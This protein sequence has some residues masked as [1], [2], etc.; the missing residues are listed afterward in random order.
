MLCL[1]NGLA[2]WLAFILVRK[3]FGIEISLP[4]IE[5]LFHSSQLGL[6]CVIAM[7]LDMFYC[8]YCCCYCYLL[9]YKCGAAAECPQFST[10]KAL[11]C[12]YT[13]LH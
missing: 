7:M 10:S 13:A 4:I 5:K 1:A 6:A 2:G 9:L 3:R 12:N 11:A 8:Y